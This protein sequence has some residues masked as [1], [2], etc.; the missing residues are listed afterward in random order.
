[1]RRT[2]VNIILDMSLKIETFVVGPLETNSYVLSS[3]AD[4]WVVDPGMECGDLLDFLR[5]QKLHPRR[6]LLTHGHGDHI[7]GVTE[8]KEAFPHARIG[9]PVGDAA[10][11][12]DP[13]ANLSG[14]FGLFVTSP[15]ADELIEPGQT[16]HL[17]QLTWTVLDTAGHT[18]GGV[19]YHCPSENVCLTGDALFASSIGRT[20]IAGGNEYQLIK[21]IRHH[22]LTLPDFTRVL[23]GHGP[24]TTVGTEKM[25]NPYLRGI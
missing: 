13:A 15:P 19:S 25:R 23:P 1:M 5:Q 3:D 21:N 17:A 12:R 18:C 4:C 9:C 14:A 10:M 16:L 20:D 2:L 22:L 8:I 11:L 7:A 6:I 24:A